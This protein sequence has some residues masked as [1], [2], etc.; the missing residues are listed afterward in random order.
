MY[1]CHNGLKEF[2]FSCSSPVQLLWP[3]GVE[4]TRLLCP[5]EFSR[6]RYWSGLPCPPPGDLPNLGIKTRSTALQ[7]DSLPSEPPGK[8]TRLQRLLHFF[9]RS[10]WSQ[11]KML[12]HFHLSTL[13]WCLVGCLPN[14]N[15][16][17]S[18]RPYYMG[19]LNCKTDEKLQDWWKTEMILWIKEG[20]STFLLLRRPLRYFHFH[21]ISFH[22]HSFLIFLS[23]CHHLYS[24]LFAEKII[25]FANSFLHP[26]CET[27]CKSFYFS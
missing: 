8:F 17:H 24:L 16:S 15:F 18:E 9:L 21:F 3:H 2:V 4:A 5:W 1:Q 23:Y 7:A 27:F 19:S 6:Q 13:N 20:L 11:K 26:Y 25:S 14:G 12:S 10:S 22:Y